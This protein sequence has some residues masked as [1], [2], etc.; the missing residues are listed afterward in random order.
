M[1]TTGF[2]ILLL[3]ALLCISSADRAVGAMFGSG[4]NTF[5]IEFVGIGNPGNV[6]DI[7]GSPNPVGSV[8]TAFRI[9]KFEISEDM[10]DKANTL[11]GLGI[12]KDARGVDKPATS[13]S[14][15]EAARFVNWL[16]TST[17]SPPAYKFAL[18]PG[19]AGYAVNANAQLW[20]AGD[21]A[22]FNPTNPYRSNLA[23]YFLPSTHEWYKAAYYNPTSGGYYDYPTGSDT[24][25]TG[26]NDG[27][28]AGTAVYN[29]PFGQGPADIM[30]AGAL[31][32]YGTM[33]QGG[34]VFE[35]EENDFDLANG[36][37]SDARGLRGGYWSSGALNLLSSN[38]VSSAPTNQQNF[39]GFRVATVP[40]PSTAMLLT[41]ASL[42][43][44]RR[45]TAR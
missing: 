14:W 42:G 24:A 23:Q 18:Q 1:K 25:P 2:G 7:T 9:G 32:H 26:V 10:I 15:N 36:P 44:L 13:V 6:A 35:L 41:L 28:A 8:A 45:R 3:A 37:S 30:L 5:D 4:A 20:A 11:G 22:A 27:T 16:N 21:G 31:S 43:L 33:G 19:D 38:R 17:G 12:T 34:N 29:R 40:E 39:I